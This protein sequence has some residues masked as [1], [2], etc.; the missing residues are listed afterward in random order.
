M[1]TSQPTQERGIAL[2]PSLTDFARMEQ[3]PMRTNDGLS[4]FIGVVQNLVEE[5]RALIDVHYALIRIALDEKWAQLIS[6]VSVSAPHASAREAGQPAN[7]NSMN[8]LLF[9]LPR[10]V[11]LTRDEM[12]AQPTWT[13]L[14]KSLR[15]PPAL[16]GLLAVPLVTRGGR[17]FGLIGLT[18]KCAGD[19]TPE[20]EKRLV[21]MAQIATLAIENAWLFRPASDA[22]AMPAQESSETGHA[23]IATNLDGVITDWNTGAEKL[24]GYS[25]RAA[26][27]Q[28]IGMLVPPERTLEH[29]DAMAKVR[30]NETVN[31]PETVRLH[32]EGKRLDVSVTAAGLHNPAGYLHGAVTVAHDI[33]AAKRLRQEY[34]QVQRMELFGQLAGGVAHDFNNMLTVILGYSEILIGGGVAGNPPREMLT[35]IH[36]A[37]VRAEALTRQLLAFSRNQAVEMKVIDLN[38]V[39]GDTEKM[40]RRLIGEDVLMTTIFAPKLWPVKIAP[41][42]MQQVILNLAINAR[43]AMPKGGRLTIET[44]NATLDETYSQQHPCVRPG[45]YVRL[46]I[47]D[48][49]VGMNA[50]TRARIFEPLFTTKAPGKGT[51]LGLTTVRNIIKQCGGHIEVYSEIGHGSTFTIYLPQVQE[52]QPAGKTVS[53]AQVVPRGDEIVLLVEDDDT[54]RSL[55]RR[56]LESCGYTVLE[57]ANG[58]DALRLADGYPGAIHLLLS[59][60][61]MPHLGGR[62]LAD[63]LLLSRPNVKILFL[64]GYTSDA[65]VR[66]GVLDADFAFLQKPFTTSSLAHKVR[67]MLDQEPPARP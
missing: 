59:D 44:D 41:G 47:S 22:G 24:F 33:T 8:S 31:Y 6:A 65:V 56:V 40:L 54:V 19:F 21:Q 39:V 45:N 3:E 20:D 66:H 25:H 1:I 67:Q 37:A 7:E 28:S 50:A 42:Q 36:S 23:V 32:Q 18:D 34:H 64:S 17:N 2:A 53:A 61:V 57:A 51:G 16:R 55:S 11:R 63:R 52:P 30:R 43:D 62:A 38:A 15:Y 46:A 14:D 4:S 29:Q 26:L 48:T 13:A 58:E 10:P 9:P 49:G 27:G 12:L 35:E 60:V 5:T